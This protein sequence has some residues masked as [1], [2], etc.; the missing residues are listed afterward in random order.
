MWVSF[1]S[2]PTLSFRISFSCL[3]LS[4]L[5]ACRRRC[6][7][8][9]WVYHV[10]SRPDRTAVFDFHKAEK[11]ARKSGGMCGC[12]FLYSLSM[13]RFL[14][15]SISIS[16][17]LSVDRDSVYEYGCTTCPLGPIAP[18]CL[19]STRRRRRPAS[20]GVCVWRVFFALYLSPALFIFFSLWA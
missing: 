10:P 15:L 20:L 17:L 12:S 18:Q 8:R 14:A 11:E 6:C 19:T 7:V 9:V 2:L 13:C 3:S 4:F 5:L 1:L 16:I